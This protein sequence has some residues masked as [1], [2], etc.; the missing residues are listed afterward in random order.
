MRREKCPAARSRSAGFTLV[1]ALVALAIAAMLMAGA[2]T[3][4]WHQRTVAARLALQRS[5]DQALENE[6][7]RLRAGAMPLAA[8]AHPAIEDPGIT[9]ILAVSA[10]TVPGTWQIDL[11]AS[12]RVQGQPFRRSLVA[13]V[14]PA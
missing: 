3:I 4:Y 12:Y 6:Y 1:E 14:R 5:A 2:S 13:L 11:V 7:E 9:L 8:G 10:G